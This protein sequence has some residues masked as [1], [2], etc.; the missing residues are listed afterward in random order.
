MKKSNIKFFRKLIISTLVC[1]FTVTVFFTGCNRASNTSEVKDTKPPT[2][3]VT[4]MEGRKVTIPTKVT[5]VVSLSN[6]TSVDLYTLAP[7]KLLGWSFSPNPNAKKYIGDKY[8]NL[9]NLGSSTGKASSFENILKLKPDLIVCSNE[10][11]VYKPDDIQKQLNIPVVM[12]D[13][14]LASTDKV[15]TF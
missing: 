9:P 3:E 1:I 8:F 13:V 7:D 15:Y 5:K 12:V 14:S 2:H 11:E 10:D 6:N 4:D